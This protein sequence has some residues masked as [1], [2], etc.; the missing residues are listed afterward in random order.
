MRVNGTVL[1]MFTVKSPFAN[2]VGMLFLSHACDLCT[3]GCSEHNLIGCR[4]TSRHRA[5]QVLTSRGTSFPP[6]WHVGTAAAG[7]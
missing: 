1:L 7:P 4:Q 6:M 3:Q 2:S 5:S